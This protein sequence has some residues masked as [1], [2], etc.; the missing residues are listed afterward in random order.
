M[1]K[2]KWILKA[3]SRFRALTFEEAVLINV[4]L[5]EKLLIILFIILLQN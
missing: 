1:M 2:G 5:I 3:S 4:E